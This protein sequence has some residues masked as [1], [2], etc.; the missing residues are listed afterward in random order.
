MI[1]TIIWD[2]DGVILDSMEIKGRGF[3]KLFKGYKDSDINKIVRYHYENGGISRFEKIKYFFKV[4]LNEEI[5]ENQINV[6]ATRFSKIIEN[7]VYDENNLISETVDFIKLNF[8]QYNFHIISGCEH[9]EL[10]QICEHFNLD[11]YFISINGSP[12]LKTLLLKTL[13]DKYCYLKVETVFIG[14]SG[15]D[16]KAAKDNDI[17]FFGFRNPKLRKVSDKYIDSFKSFHC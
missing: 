2:F 6:L 15:S 4:I 5:S 17:N 9:N 7:E 8:N 14:D 13:L 1:S 12:T 10:L 11:K 16:Y 3:A